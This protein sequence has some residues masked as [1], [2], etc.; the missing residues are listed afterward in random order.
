MP[1]GLCPYPAIYQ[2]CRAS[3]GTNAARLGATLPVIDCSGWVGLL[4]KSVM[5]RR[6]PP[7]VY[8]KGAHAGEGFGY[9]FYQRC[10]L[11]ASIESALLTI[12]VEGFTPI[13]A[14][15]GG[16]DLA[17]TMLKHLR[18]LSL[19]GHYFETGC[20]LLDQLP[21]RIGPEGG[22]ASRPSRASLRLSGVRAR[23]RR[24]GSASSEGV[25]G[26]PNRPSVA[27]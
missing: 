9:L 7:K 8:E 15:P 24:A 26:C 10:Q 22:V 19:P 21:S 23:C 3:A 20:L 18:P 16:E 25:G 4:L 17:V 14:V 13:R 2:P 1:I 5:S 12:G 6:S 11:T 27:T